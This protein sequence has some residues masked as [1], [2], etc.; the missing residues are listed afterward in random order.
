MDEE[1]TKNTAT[2]NEG[3]LQTVVIRMAKYI[4]EVTGECPEY[5]HDYKKINCQK[6]CGEDGR[7][8]GDFSKCWIDYFNDKSV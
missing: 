2:D 5:E 7:R 6:V 3:Q 1:K 4:G 8:Y